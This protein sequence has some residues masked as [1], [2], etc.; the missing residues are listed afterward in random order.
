MRPLPSPTTTSVSVP[1]RLR[2]G[3]RGHAADL[4][5][6]GH[7][8]ADLD[9]GEVG[10]L[11][12]RGRSGAGSAAAGRG[13]CAGRAARPCPSAVF[14]PEHARQRRLQGRPPRSLDP[15]LQ[16]DAAGAAAVADHLDRWGAARPGARRPRRRAPSSGPTT[17]VAIS[18]P[19]ESSRSSRSQATAARS[20]PMTTTSPSAEPSDVAGLAAAGRGQRLL[21]GDG[22]LGPAG[23]G[24]G[25][26]HGDD[27]VA[28]A[29]AGVGDGDRGQPLHRRAG[30]DDADLAA[31]RRGRG[32][33]PG[34]RRADQ[35][36]RRWAAPTTSAARGG[37][38]LVEH[39]VLGDAVRA[40]GDDADPLA[41]EQLGEPVARRRRR[42]RRGVPGTGA[43]GGTG[44]SGVTEIR[45]GPAGLDAGLDGGP[46]VGDVDVDVPLPARR[47]VDADDDEAVAERGEPVR[48]GARRRPRRLSASR[49]CTSLP[50]P[51]GGWC[52]RCS[53]E[54]WW[55]RVVARGPA[56][57]GPA[58]RRSRW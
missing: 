23:G 55:R 28:E 50:G 15:H 13:R 21:L 43:G 1:R 11:A 52:G 35:R 19:A 51:A 41:G 34:R 56:A 46:D 22:H 48:A 42:P 27:V 30:G 26:G 54:W 14:G 33:R 12:A 40:A 44:A 37:D 9:V 53:P 36:R 49:Y 2:I 39:V 10:L 6:H 18:P 47:G 45:Y 57:R 5:Q 38:D 7:P 16:R 24:G 17:R 25:L 58:R 31:L 4:G 29:A 3:R 32:R 8:V 20:R